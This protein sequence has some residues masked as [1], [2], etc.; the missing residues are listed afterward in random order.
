[1]SNQPWEE[2]DEQEEPEEQDY[3]IAIVRSRPIRIRFEVRGPEDDADRKRLVTFYRDRRLAQ[4]PVTQEELQEISGS[5]AWSE[6]VPLVGLARY[7]EGSD[8]LLLSLRAE[9]ASRFGPFDSDEAYI[10]LGYRYRPRGRQVFP[11]DLDRETRDLFGSLLQGRPDA[12]I[13][14]L[15]EDA[16]RDASWRDAYRR[17]HDGHEPGRDIAEGVWSNRIRQPGG[18]R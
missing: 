4:R 15:F 12:A 2:P 1:M 11:G 3:P 17:E 13:A 8:T 6:P 7:A 14:K 9:A 5:T 10:W 16:R 18:D